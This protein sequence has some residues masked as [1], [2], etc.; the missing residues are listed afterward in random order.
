M[1]MKH[2][3]VKSECD[4]VLQQVACVPQ[5]R[6]LTQRIPALQTQLE[7]AL[8]ADDFG[9]IASVGTQLLALQQQSAQLPQSEEDYLTLADRHAALV[10]ATTGCATNH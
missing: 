10:Q 4:R 7:A 9:S 3:C 5:R 8:A 6:D 1:K 2:T